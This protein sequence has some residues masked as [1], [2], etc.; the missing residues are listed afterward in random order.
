MEAPSFLQDQLPAAAICLLL[1]ILG[2]WL[3]TRKSKKLLKQLAKMEKKV[4][5]LNTELLYGSD[6]LK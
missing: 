4:M 3:G 1:F 2:Y 5:D 6:S